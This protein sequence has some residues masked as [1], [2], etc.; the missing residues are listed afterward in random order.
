MGTKLMRRL[1]AVLIVL[2]MVITS[3]CMVFAAGTS[4]PSEG[5][6]KTPVLTKQA[7]KAYP[8]SGQMTVTITAKN[9]KSYLIAYRKVGAKKWSYVKSTN[10]KATI[11]NLA[12]RGYY[13]IISKAYNGKVGSNK[14]TVANRWMQSSLGVK[15]AGSKG[16]ATLSW[17]KIIGANGYKITYAPAENMSKYKTVTVKSGATVKS[18]L[19][20]LKKGTYYYY[21]RPYKVV[22]KTV[23]LGASSLRSF[24]VK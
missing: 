14:S 1:A 10:P 12:R 6:K 19:S 7:T 5:G 11:K 4:S 16:K 18:V 23:Y 21:V 2:V 3:G 8:G 24:T 22:G 17:T 20:N 15:A 13:Q 9:A